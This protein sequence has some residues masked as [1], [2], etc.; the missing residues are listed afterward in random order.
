[1]ASAI[2]ESVSRLHQ[3]VADTMNW[4][5]LQEK[6]RAVRSSLSD[7]ARTVPS[8][9]WIVVGA[10]LLGA[11]SG[12]L[13]IGV[14]MPGRP[15]P[16]ADAEVNVLTARLA[17]L[18]EDVASL[19]A[20]ETQELGFC[21]N[22]TAPRNDTA[23]PEAASVK[24]EEVV[25]DYD[26][27]S[28]RRPHREPAEDRKRWELAAAATARL[29]A[30][31]M[32]DEDLRPDPDLTTWVSTDEPSPPPARP[33]DVAMAR[34]LLEAGD[35]RLSR[36]DLDEAVSEYAKAAQRDATTDVGAEA[37]RKQAEVL[38]SRGDLL[39]SVDAYLHLAGFLKRNG[40]NFSEEV[41]AAL[42]F[43]DAACDGDSADACLAHAT[44]VLSLVGEL[45]GE[46]SIRALTVLARHGDVAAARL[47]ARRLDACAALRLVA[48]ALQTSGNTAN[49]TVA[50]RRC[51]GRGCDPP[52]HNAFALVWFDYGLATLQDDPVTSLSALGAAQDLGHQG[53]ELDRAIKWALDRAH[54]NPPTSKPSPPLRRD[55]L[56]SDEPA[57]ASPAKEDARDEKLPY[58]NATAV[59]EEPAAKGPLPKWMR[60]ISPRLRRLPA[61]VRDETRTADLPGEADIVAAGP[62]VPDN[63][64]KDH[65]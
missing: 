57:V 60:R 28:Q 56:G 11:L 47:V 39:A 23:R 12:G 62:V 55:G 42:D 6:S 53:E 36:G 48:A 2:I 52:W 13:V 10:F 41:G 65:R 19:I 61:V 25:T 26:L 63:V 51:A 43:L 27:R 32:T 5:G 20:R 14:M 54:K 49:A 1:M 17:R 16:E 3:P 38:A 21:R 40:S 45:E 31:A 22:D 58:A 15:A 37:R 4:Q 18:E 59:D 44:R 50:A 35:R 30:A 24:L 34:A 29:E 9:V 33:A 46:A 7:R 8:S 64:E